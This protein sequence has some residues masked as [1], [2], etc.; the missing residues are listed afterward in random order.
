M[1]KKIN[2]IHKK[3]GNILRDYPTA[4]DSDKNLFINYCHVYH[5]D[6]N[7]LNDVIDKKVPAFET[8]SRCRRKYQEEGEYRASEVVQAAR[9]EQVTMF[10][11]FSRTPNEDLD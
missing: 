9:E 10:Q 11:E 7:S 4:R 5:P 8:I 2:T 1:P 3:V 6:V